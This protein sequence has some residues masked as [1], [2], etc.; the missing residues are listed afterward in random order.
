MVRSLS[1]L[2]PCLHIGVHEVTFAKGR[3]LQKCFSN[4]LICRIAVSSNGGNISSTS[5]KDD[6]ERL[7]LR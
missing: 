7:A 4:I 3:V 5:W 1:V 6:R 2:S